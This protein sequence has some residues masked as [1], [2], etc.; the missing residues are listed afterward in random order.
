M[1]RL[2]AEI[3]ASIL[4]I[5]LKAVAAVMD[6]AT[7]KFSS[8]GLSVRGLDMAEVKMVDLYLPSSSF[9]NYHVA[10]EQKIAIRMSDVV[11]GGYNKRTGPFKRPK[12]GET[13]RLEY[14]GGPKFS[15]TLKGVAG[16]MGLSLPVL[17]G[18]GKDLP[19]PKVALTE[20]FTARTEAMA[21]F[22]DAAQHCSDSVY[23]RPR[24]DGSME[25]LAKGEITEMSKVLSLKDGTLTQSELHE[26][27]SAFEIRGL[28]MLLQK[29]FGELA[30]MEYGRDLPLKITYSLSAGDLFREKGWV[31]FYM[32]PRVERDEPPT[33]PKN[34]T[35]CDSCGLKFD[36]VTVEEVD[37]KAMDLCDKCLEQVKQGKRPWRERLEQTV[38]A[39]KDAQGLR[40]GSVEVFRTGP[41][42][43]GFGDYAHCDGEDITH[44]LKVLKSILLK[45]DLGWIAKDYDDGMYRGEKPLT[46]KEWE[47]KQWQATNIYHEEM[48]DITDWPEIEAEEVM[49]EQP[50]E[51]KPVTITTTLPSELEQAKEI[52]KEILGPAEHKVKAYACENCGSDISEGTGKRLEDG[53]TWLCDACVNDEKVKYYYGK[54]M[55]K[56]EEPKPEPVQV[57]AVD[58]LEAF[59]KKFAKKT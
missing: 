15:F 13:V 2:E 46:D 1:T 49:P 3:D 11:G 19:V 9:E 10:E 17:A 54:R 42:I 24:L 43:Y 35:E 39:S 5:A 58:P 51:E 45:E 47:Q 50:V 34:Q 23:F 59:R 29:P 55:P 57:V 33:K 44:N 37:G 40:P 20:K 32:A 6:E 38:Q 56:P 28:S 31:V 48:K 36:S 52:V 4:Y 41:R 14:D 21:S 12:K 26:A 22:L 16:M 30:E 7:L 25:F 18:D 53:D 27:V 8:E